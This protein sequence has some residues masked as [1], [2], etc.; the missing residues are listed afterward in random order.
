MKHISIT[1]LAALGMLLGTVPVARAAD[2]TC[3][4]QTISNATISGNLVVTGSCTLGSDVRVGGNVTVEKGASLTISPTTSPV[5][6]GGNILTVRGCIDV[7]IEAR[8]SGPVTIGGNV[9]IENCQEGF[10]QD[11][12]IGGNF[13]CTGNLFCLVLSASI[14][15]NVKV[16]DNT[17]GE[18]EVNGNTIGGNVEF[19]GNPDESEVASNTISGNVEVDG[20]AVDSV[21]TANT[22]GGNLT[23][24]GNVEFF[25]GTGNT[26]H[27]QILPKPVSQCGP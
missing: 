16:N 26:V 4:N 24:T 13:K 22:I 14:G 15:G 5:K 3:G 12:K 8:S 27:G 9:E 19:D 11:V 10:V 2:A 7:A 18:S 6:I 20:N 1:T 21:V 17:S 25:Q 23:C